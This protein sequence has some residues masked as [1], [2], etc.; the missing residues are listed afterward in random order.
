[1]VLQGARADQVVAS[2]K[3]LDRGGPL[4]AGSLKPYGAPGVVPS[5]DYYPIPNGDD[6]G[7]YVYLPQL[8]NWAGTED[9]LI[10]LKWSF[11]TLFAALLLMYPLIFYELFSSVLAA[12]FAPYL[13]LYKF[14]FLFDTDI[15]WITGWAVLFCLP[16]LFVVYKRWTPRLGLVWLALL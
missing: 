10:V 13:L 2:I 5:K 11:I 14:V 7:P 8:A 12:V 4:L 9:P 15:Y 16:L 1:M 3:V 6:T